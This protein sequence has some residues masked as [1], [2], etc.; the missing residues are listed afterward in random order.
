[1]IPTLRLAAAVAALSLAALAQTPTPAP[2]PFPLAPPPGPQIYPH[3]MDESDAGFVP[4]FDG[5]SLQNWEGDPRYWR[6]QDH[7]LVGEVT[8]A[9]LLKQNNFIIW[10]GGAPANFELKADYRIT[11]HG[12]S[13]INYRSV[14]IPGTRYLLR[15]Y[16]AD[17]DGESR[18]TGQNYE[19]RGRT[20]L[21]MRGTMTHVGADGATV[22]ASLGD[23]EAL[24]AYIHTDD[25]NHY[26]LIVRGNVMIHILN[27][28]VMS[29]VIDDD[30]AHRTFSGLIGVQVHVGPP[31]KVEYRSILLK[32]LPDGK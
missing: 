15:G 25:W 20:F 11:A 19:E 32:V 13:G 4:I 30:A 18:Y 21:A 24:Q 28:H 1:M 16:Q 31:M 14:E 17:I 9:T 22:I 23:A 3:P 2:S 26:H 12:N 5:N 7:E 10:R 8:P 29:E 27:G 6:V